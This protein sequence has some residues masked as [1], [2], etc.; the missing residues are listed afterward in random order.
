[1]ADK[2]VRVRNA[3][4]DDLETILTLN[5]F[6]QR[7]HAEALP[8]LFRL[9]VESQQSVDAFSAILT[10]PDSLVLLA[11]DAGP[12]GYLYAQFQSRPASW[13]Q[14]ASQVLY[15]QHMVIAPKFRRRGVGTLLLSGATESAHSRGINRVELDVWAFNSEA[16][17]FYAKHGFEVFNERMQLSIN[18][19]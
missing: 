18:R 3:S 7:Q 12:V 8:R 19:A 2:F 6:V 15:I 5:G 13:V 11:E 9:P 1:L 17:R 14:L 4:I 10:S 16:R